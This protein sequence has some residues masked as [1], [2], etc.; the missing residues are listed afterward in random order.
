MGEDIMETHKG[1]KDQP[2]KS[3]RDKI[4]A[5]ILIYGLVMS[6]LWVGL[7]AYTFMRVFFNPQKAI[8]LTVNTVGEAN[9]EFVLLF[10]AVPVVIYT[11]YTLGRRVYDETFRPTKN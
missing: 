4:H 11:A 1:N 3:I 2:K 5:G 6:V 7:M 9:P 8:V 10:V